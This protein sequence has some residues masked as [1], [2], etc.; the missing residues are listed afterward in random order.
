MCILHEEVVLLLVLHL[1]L[2]H[3][4]PLRGEVLLVCT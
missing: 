2:V 4:V 1:G 3:A